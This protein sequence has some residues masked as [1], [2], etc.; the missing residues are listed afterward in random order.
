MKIDC[1][2]TIPS[3]E[4]FECFNIAYSG[5]LDEK[6]SIFQ[7]MKEDVQKLRGCMKDIKKH[8]EGDT[9][10]IGGVVWKRVNDNWHFFDKDKKTWTTE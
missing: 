2:V 5:E 8:E 10:M 1:R 3:G 4:Q 7:M 6:D 9:F